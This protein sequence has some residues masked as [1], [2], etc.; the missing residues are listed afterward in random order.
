MLTAFLLALHALVS[1]GYAA[2]PDLDQ[3]AT[4]EP[5]KVHSGAHYRHYVAADAAVR[6]G[7]RTRAG[8]N[9]LDVAR[10]S[11]LLVYKSYGQGDHVESYIC[12]ATAMRFCIMLNLNLEIEQ[13][14]KGQL[15]I[16]MVEPYITHRSVFRGDPRDEI[17]A[18]EMRRTMLIAFLV[19]RTS[20]I[21]TLWPTMLCEED[22]TAELP[23][24]TMHEFVTTT[25]TNLHSQSWTRQYNASAIHDSTIL[26]QPAVD[27]EQFLF[28]SN[29]LLGRCALHV[30]R[31]SRRATADQIT[32]SFQFQQLESWIASVQLEAQDV[33]KL[34]ST[35]GAK[36]GVI[37]GQVYRSLTEVLSAKGEPSL[38][39]LGVLIAFTF[40]H[41]CTLTLHEPIANLDLESAARCAAAT[42]E[43]ITAL[44][45]CALHAQDVLQHMDIL[46]TIICT[47]AGRS[48]VRQLERAYVNF[49]SQQLNQQGQQRGTG[50]EA[51]VFPQ[52]WTGAQTIDG[53]HDLTDLVSRIQADL[54]VVLLTLKR[55]GEKWQCAIKLHDSLLQLLDFNPDDRYRGLFFSGLLNTQRSS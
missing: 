48:L 25:T 50:Q 31:I 15:R 11:L 8:G 24:A 40:P 45:S 46:L 7:M 10:A 33:P 26:L 52:V 30:S 23:R 28:K 44:R 39:K 2:R 49:I 41:A 9:A 17:E 35:A 54:R 14:P 22:Y 42:H 1:I 32:S 12:C 47:L 3:A 20:A 21:A 4:G 43:I 37:S 34:L 27:V 19:D 29:V 18:E 38:R 55:I 13:D 16:P 5:P 51:D 6:R 53:T 36:S